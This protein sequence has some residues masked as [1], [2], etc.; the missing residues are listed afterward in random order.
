MARSFSRLAGA[1]ALLALSSSAAAA[2]QDKEDP[3]DPVYDG[4][5][6]SVWVD[7]LVNGT[8]ARQRAL[9][10][11]ALSKLWAEK[12]YE[13]AIPNI[14]RSLRLD[15]S[16]AVRAQAAVALG[17]LREVEVK[18]LLKERQGV[19]VKDLVDAMGAEKEARVRKEIA[20]SIARYPDLAVLAVKHLTEALKDADPETR[21]V[22]AEALALTGSAAKSAADGL[23]QL[24]ADE[25]KSV[26]RAAV[27]ALGRTTPEGS[28]AI[29]ETMRA[30]LLSSL[31]EPWVCENVSA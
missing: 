5:K 19:G 6:A 16:A 22:A 18:Y 11:E 24:L 2:R 17:G 13:D 29:A 26:R 8:S 7:T 12:R 3:K 10:V 14:G 15:T 25:N 23:A 9:A 27:I 31:P 4:K 21:A 1:V 20:R 30:S 28:P